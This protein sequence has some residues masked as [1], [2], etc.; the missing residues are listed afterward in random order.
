VSSGDIPPV[1]K[2]VASD[3]VTKNCCSF[4]SCSVVEYDPTPLLK[5]DGGI[6]KTC[7]VPRTGRIS[8]RNGG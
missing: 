3:I 6:L 1:A 5:A 8:S 2:P 4:A 7:C